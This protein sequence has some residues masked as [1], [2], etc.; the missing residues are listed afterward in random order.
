MPFAIELSPR[1]SARTMEQAIRHRA[2]VL[3][4]PRVWES[5]EPVTCRFEPSPDGGG[6]REGSGVIVLSYDLA[7]EAPPDVRLRMEEFYQLSGTYCDLA[8]RLGENVYLC[9]SDVTRVTKPLEPPSGLLIHLSRPETLQV[10]QR[11]RYRRFPLADSTRVRI[12]WRREGEPPSEG[13]GWLCNV[14]ADGLACR[15]DVNIGEQLFIGE[16]VRVDFSL[17]RTDPQRFV[18]DAVICNKTPAGTQGKMIVGLHFLIDS[19][20]ASAVQMAESLRNKLRERS[21]LPTRTPGPEGF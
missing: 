21:M 14:S 16:T 6:R 7:V 2:E 19:Q 4:E 18:F 8:I 20:L 5:Q 10:A 9:S 15:T 1:Q 13:T 12:T 17:A 11:R 3:M